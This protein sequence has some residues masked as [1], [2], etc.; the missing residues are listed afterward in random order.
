MSKR[1][2]EAITPTPAEEK[3]HGLI[4][5][6]H[7]ISE[8]TPTGQEPTNSAIEDD[9]ED[10]WSSEGSDRCVAE[11]GSGMKRKPGK[12]RA[13]KTVTGHPHHV[14]A[15]RPRRRSFRRAHSLTAIE[16]TGRDEDIVEEQR[17]RDIRRPS[18]SRPAVTLVSFAEG[19]SQSSSGKT[20]E[21]THHH[22]SRAMRPSTADGHLLRSHARP[23]TGDSG[24]RNHRVES[25]LAQYSVPP[26][27]EN[28]P[29]R[30]VRFAQVGESS[31][32]SSKKSSAGM[33]DVSG[34]D[35]LTGYGSPRS[36]PL[37]SAQVS[38]AP[39]PIPSSPG[40]VH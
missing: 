30:S 19:T 33:T 17:G 40:A 38:R 8:N 9:D 20:G 15:H 26:T 35:S 18:T 3:E 4:D 21:P 13:D 6:G 29:S 22:R 1:T 36:S 12:P 37:V 32:S 27:R 16:F 7:T 2:K 24:P 25:I 5:G 11:R 23:G 39:S 14:S 31:G 10:A 34:V 28:S